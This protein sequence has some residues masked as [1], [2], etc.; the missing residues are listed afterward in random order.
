[1][2]YQTIFG[3]HASPQCHQAFLSDISAGLKRRAVSAQGC[4]VKH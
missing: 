4:C 2:W 3:N 1:M